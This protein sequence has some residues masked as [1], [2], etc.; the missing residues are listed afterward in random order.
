MAPGNL[1]LSGRA[2]IQN[3]TGTA[4]NPYVRLSEIK[5]LA[6]GTNADPRPLVQPTNPAYTEFLLFTFNF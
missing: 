6:S 3:I 5:R 1:P 4:I 2:I